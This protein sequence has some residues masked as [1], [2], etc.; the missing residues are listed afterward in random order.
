V[1]DAGENRRKA[2]VKMRR[3]L[4]IETAAANIFLIFHEFGAAC[5]T[6]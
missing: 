5:F 3:K 2:C 1:V 4:Q 6:P